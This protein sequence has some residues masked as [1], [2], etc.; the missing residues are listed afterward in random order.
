MNEY[1]L[2]V[3]KKGDP[4]WYGN[5]EVKKYKFLVNALLR[6][7]TYVFTRSHVSIVWGN[8]GVL[9]IKN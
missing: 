5:V 9:N 8:S 2:Q 6:S 1:K 4:S 7:L 3:T